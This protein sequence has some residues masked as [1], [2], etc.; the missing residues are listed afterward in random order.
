VPNNLLIGS[1]EA[2][3]GQSIINTGLPYDLTAPAS[4]ADGVAGAQSL[5]A[6]G[7][8][9][10]DQAATLFAGGDYGDTVYSDLL[11]ADLVSI[12]PLEELIL[13]SVASF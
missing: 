2:L 13:G 12:V 11:G 7:Q 5:I 1:V 6:E 3:V 9:Y 8:A 10:F 4:F